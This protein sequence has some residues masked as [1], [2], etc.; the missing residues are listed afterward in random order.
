MIVRALAHQAAADRVENVLAQ[1]DGG[2]ADYDR[3]GQRGTLARP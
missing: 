3:C 2:T 1:K